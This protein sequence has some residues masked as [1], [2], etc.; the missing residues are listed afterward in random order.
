MTRMWSSRTRRFVSRA[1]GGSDCESQ[2]LAVP[3]CFQFVFCVRACGLSSGVV[4]QFVL[5]LCVISTVMTFPRLSQ[6]KTHAARTL[7]TPRV[8]S[9]LRRLTAWK[10]RQSSLNSCRSTY[11]TPSLQMWSKDWGSGG[12]PQVLLREKV[13]RTK[14]DTRSL[15]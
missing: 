7:N 11:T 13:V 6:E 14:V 5:W 10:W 3:S 12:K 1:T 8:S 9:W 2:P 15:S 4:R